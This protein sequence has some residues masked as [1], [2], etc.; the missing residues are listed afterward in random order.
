MSFSE[1]I[2]FYDP[3]D[4]DY[5]DCCKYTEKTPFKQQR[6]NWKWKTKDKKEIRIVDMTDNH[7]FN[8]YIVSGDEKLFSEMVVRLF[9]Q[10]L[11]TH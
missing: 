7:L 8:A 10:R 4:F 3:E 11:N 1:D 6:L 5:H 9:N 2:D